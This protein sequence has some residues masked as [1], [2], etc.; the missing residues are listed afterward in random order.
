MFDRTKIQRALISRAS[1]SQ[2]VSWY[3]QHQ[4]T[5]ISL[6]ALTILRAC[7]FIRTTLYRFYYYNLHNL[8]Y[9]HILL[10]R[11]MTV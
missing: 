1:A 6:A 4:Q 5:G 8:H 7:T 11:I 2:L 3:E 9:S 10:L